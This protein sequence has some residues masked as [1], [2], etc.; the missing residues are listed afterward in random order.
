M[1]PS[2]SSLSLPTGADVCSRICLM[3]FKFHVAWV[4]SYKTYGELE[5]EISTQEN[6]FKYFLPNGHVHSLFEA[7]TRGRARENQSDVNPEFTFTCLTLCC[8]RVLIQLSLQL[9]LPHT[10][11][12]KPHRPQVITFHICGERNISQP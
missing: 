8:S 9:G 12:S 11:V 7:V 10:T 6:M 1:F 3:T 2:P 4:V 5:T